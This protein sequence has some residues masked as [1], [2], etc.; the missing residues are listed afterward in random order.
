MY[1]RKPYQDQD[2]N[3]FNQIAQDLGK[4]ARPASQDEYEDYSNGEPYDIG[5]ISALEWWC[6]DQQRKRWPR[7]SFMAIDILSIPAMSDTP[8]RAISG[9]RRTISWER[10][11]L[12]AENIERVEFLKHCK[13]SGIVKDELRVEPEA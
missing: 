3:E 6:Q 2:L 13:R 11:R 1:K 4:Y 5:K 7:L 10:A 12:G 9:G 8:E